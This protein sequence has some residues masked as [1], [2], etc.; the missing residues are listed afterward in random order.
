M[1]RFI[2][3]NCDMGELVDGKIDE[4]LMSYI[5]SCNIACGYHAGSSDQI[6]KTIKLAQKH[7][8]NIGAHPSYNDRANFGRVS[9]DVSSDQLQRDIEDQL[10]TI[11][12]IANEEGASIHHLKPHGDLYNDMAKDESKAMTVL[13]VVKAID[14]GLII[15]ALSGSKVVKAAKSL[16]MNYKEEAFMDRSYETTIKL[17]SRSYDNAIITDIT[18]IKNQLKGLLNHEIKLLGG[19]V[20]L[21]QVD[22][23]C[24]HSDTLGAVEIAKAIHQYLKEQDVTLYQNR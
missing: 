3:I 15:Y 23:I 5:S 11:Q 10:K 4:L 12:K 7:G 9:I 17:R 2:D 13:E 20:A 22:T 1:K 6:R 19:E 21:I 18:Q 16:K 14:H 8:V 24:L